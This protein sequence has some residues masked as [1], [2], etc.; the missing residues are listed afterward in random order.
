MIRR[1]PRSTRT[2]TLFPYTTLFRSLGGQRPGEQTVPTEQREQ[3]ARHRGGEAGD[4]RIGHRRPFA[5]SSRLRKQCVGRHHP[6]RDR[7]RKSVVSGKR[8]SVSVDLGGSRIIQKKKDT[9]IY[10]NATQHEPP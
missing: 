9:S 10:T 3:L 5:M 7:D 8:V 4:P 6:P 1:P 2:D